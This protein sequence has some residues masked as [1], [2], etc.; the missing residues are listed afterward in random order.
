MAAPGL[1]LAAPLGGSLQTD[2][3]GWRCLHHRWCQRR[4]R[5]WSCP[6][7][8]IHSTWIEMDVEIPSSV[9]ATSDA[10]VEEVR[11]VAF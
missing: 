5:C 8:R 3:E 9:E 7:R 10:S 11:E 1:V 6:L 4:R 2:G